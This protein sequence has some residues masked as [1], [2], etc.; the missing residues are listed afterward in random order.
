MRQH[1]ESYHCIAAAH[2]VCTCE[3]VCLRMLLH[4][5]QREQNKPKYICSHLLGI[6]DNIL[7]VDKYDGHP[8]VLGV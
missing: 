4:V 2:R 5:I 6:R 3:N 8:S 1:H 7:N